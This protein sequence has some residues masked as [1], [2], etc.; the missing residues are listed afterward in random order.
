MTIDQQIVGI[1]SEIRNGLLSTQTDYCD[2]QEAARIIGLNN[3]RDLKKLYDQ[4]VLPRYQRGTAYKYKKTDC[5]K[6]A[7]ML[8]NNQIQL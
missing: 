7:A 2:T 5:H 3:T 6:V 8:D 4:G 1:L